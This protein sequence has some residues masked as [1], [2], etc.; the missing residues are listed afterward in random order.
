MTVK[1]YDE[2]SLDLAE[3]FLQDEPNLYTNDACHHLACA[4]QT[5]VENWI[6]DAKRNT[7]P[8]DPPGFEAGFAENH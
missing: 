2:K 6:E 7:E 5:A 4:I 8:R 3:H 1:T